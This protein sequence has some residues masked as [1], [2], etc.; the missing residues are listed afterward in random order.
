MFRSTTPS[1]EVGIEHYL[2]FTWLCCFSRTLVTPFMFQ[3]QV[4]LFRRLVGFLGQTRTRRKTRT[5]IC[6]VL[7]VLLE[8]NPF[9][10]FCPSQRWKLLAL[11][12]V[13]LRQAASGVLIMRRTKTNLNGFR[14]FPVTCTT[15]TTMTR[16]L[17][18]HSGFFS[19]S[20]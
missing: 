14:V 15:H 9:K 6:V 10:L 8:M 2:S 11:L 20:L 12:G 18:S 17:D 7:G 3:N 13:W 19:P 5:N 4:F 1:C 16:F